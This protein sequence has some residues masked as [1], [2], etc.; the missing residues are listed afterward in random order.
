MH[1]TRDMFFLWT[2]LKKQETVQMILNNPNYW[3][4]ILEFIW[5]EMRKDEEFKM[6]MRN[7]KDK[8]KHDLYELKERYHVLEDLLDDEK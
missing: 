3:V 6:E 8:Y 1:M 7:I 5:D 2:D 4:A